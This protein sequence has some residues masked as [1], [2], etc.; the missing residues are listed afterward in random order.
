[1]ELKLSFGRRLAPQVSEHSNIFGYIGLH[2][3]LLIEASSKE[4]RDLIEKFHADLSGGLGDVRERLAR[5]EGFLK[6][7][8]PDHQDP[9]EGTPA[10]A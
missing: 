4:N 10:A 9:E 6:T 7:W 5:I 1:M 2:H 8:P 3:A